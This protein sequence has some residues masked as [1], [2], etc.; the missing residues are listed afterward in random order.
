MTNITIEASD[1]GWCMVAEG[2]AGYN[3]GGPDIVCAAVSM[4]CCALEKTI[5]QLG[6]AVSRRDSGRFMLKCWPDSPMIWGAIQMG[7]TA[8]AMIAETYPEHVKITYK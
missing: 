2:H 7:K 6:Q 8:L 1:G 3:P 4:V 5:H